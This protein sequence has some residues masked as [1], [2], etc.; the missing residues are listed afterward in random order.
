MAANTSIGDRIF[1]AAASNVARTRKAP[2]PWIAAA[3]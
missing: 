1:N 3:V 2:R